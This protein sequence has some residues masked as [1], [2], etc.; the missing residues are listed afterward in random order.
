MD[1]PTNILQLLMLRW[2][3]SDLTRNNIATLRL[4]RP[5]I[6]FVN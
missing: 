6:D 4:E 1:K 5:E 2:F 3:R